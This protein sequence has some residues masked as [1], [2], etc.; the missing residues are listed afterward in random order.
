MPRTLNPKPYILHPK[1]YTLN[2]TPSTL[3]PQPSTLDPQPHPPQSFPATGRRRG[4]RV[5][6]GAVVGGEARLFAHAERERQQGRMAKCSGF[7]L[8]I[9]SLFS[10]HSVHDYWRHQYGGSGWGVQ[11]SRRRARCLATPT[12]SK[13]CAL[14]S[15]TLGF[16]LHRFS[17][18]SSRSAHD[19]YII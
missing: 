14:G 10:S 3:N 11:F 1:P 16:W 15:Q 13:G 4:Q 17:L 19:D 12:R 2:P 5:I 18:F 7:W 6:E 8:Q 9:F